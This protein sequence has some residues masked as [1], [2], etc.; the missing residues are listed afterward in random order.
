VFIDR[1]V[2]GRVELLPDT[3]LTKTARETVRQ[4]WVTVS[5]ES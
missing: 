3:T 1:S 4:K 2:A 5:R